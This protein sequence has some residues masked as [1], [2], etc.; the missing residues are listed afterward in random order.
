MRIGS[1]TIKVPF[2]SPQSTPTAIPA[3]AE[4]LPIW[5]Y[6]FAGFAASLVSIGLARFAYA[7]LV[8]SL[9]EA[10]WFSSS[11]VVFLGAAN[12][13]GYLVGALIG[14]PVARRFSSVHALR[15]MMVFVTAAFV[16]CA[17]PLS[18][19]WFFF[20]RLISGI[21][22]GAI[23]VL[24]A[25]TVLPHV[26]RERRGLAG[27]AI[28]LGIGVGIAGSGTVVPLLLDV[29]LRATWLGLAAI[30]AAL[31]A[32]T[33]FAWPEHHGQPHTAHAQPAAAHTEPGIAL[34]FGQYG[35]MA[36]ALVPAMVFLVDFVARGLGAG[37]SLGAR[38]WVIYGVG[39]MMGP[40]LYGWLADHLGARPAMRA[41]LLAQALAVGTLW[42]AGNHAWLALAT[43]FVGMFP[44]GIVP[45]TLA[46]IHE[47][48]PHDEHAQNRARSRATIT[49]AS[50]QAV[51][52]YAYSAMYSVTGGNH[53]LL[54]AIATGALV[55]ALAAELMGARWRLWRA[56]VG[57]A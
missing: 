34:L 4:P 53:R 24:V 12:L 36:V 35:L 16:A 48:I 51:A 56:A 40:P 11:H 42:L 49:F 45:L 21:S 10:N 9:I 2:V 39:A 37:A 50:C 8:P 26:P 32:A 17:W 14:H 30:A 27:G 38:F 31:T 57:A 43:L 23:M 13:A 20:W 52:G 22:G 7:P 28:F 19:S 1:A 44:P 33:W 54:F 3:L 18:V 6:I 47:L 25:A 55:V 29:G 15:A 46:R 5:R 41:V